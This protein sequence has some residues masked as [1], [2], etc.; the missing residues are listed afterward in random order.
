MTVRSVAFLGAA[1]LLTASVALADSAGRRGL[2]TSSDCPFTCRDLGLKSDTCR[3]WEAGD[4]C[5]VE[6]LTQAPGHRS[7]M[8]VPGAPSSKPSARGRMRRD[9]EGT[10]ITLTKGEAKGDAPAAAPA[11]GKRG[12][13]TTAPCP[14]SCASAGLEAANCREW[15]DGDSCHVEDLLQAPGHRTAVS[16]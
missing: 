15:Q 1:L 16:R 3:E 5:F 9:T 2:I 8:R 10:W 7:L 4:S 6:D 14:F 12:L 11:P 13:V